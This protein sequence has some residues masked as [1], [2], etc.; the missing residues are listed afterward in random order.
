[1][2]GNGNG[3]VVLT[4]SAMQAFLTCPRKYFWRYVAEVEPVE[5][6]E[7][8]V[9]GSAVHRYLEFFYSQVP[10]DRELLLTEGLSPKARGIL[11]GVINN[12]GRVYPDDINQFE[13]LGVEHVLSGQKK[14][15]KSIKDIEVPV[16]ASVKEILKSGLQAKGTRHEVTKKIAKYFYFQSM[17]PEAAKAE[18][19]D[20][21]QNRHNGNSTTINKGRWREV[22]ADISSMVDWFWSRFPK[23]GYWPTYN[24]NRQGWVTRPD[25]L[26]ITDIFKGNLT[27]QKRFFKLISIFRSRLNGH[28]EFL[29]LPWRTWRYIAGDN[30]PK[31]QA[32]L[33]RMKALDMNGSYWATSNGTGYCKSFR[34]NIRQVNQTDMIQNDGRAVQNYHQ[35]LLSVFKKVKDSVQAAGIPKRGFYEN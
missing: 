15:Y 28:I 7:S 19:W 25:I 29:R 24:H 22:R 9:L 31:F 14:F 33:E 10:V 27:M 2:N 17:N 5:K 23:N 12:Y 3:K 16:M 30:Y 35:A 21:F 34:L 26:F 6:S 4:Y 32:A 11:N 13:V 20:F 8:L 18:I 1:M